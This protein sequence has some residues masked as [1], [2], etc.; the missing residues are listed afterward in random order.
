[1]AFEAIHSMV[2][3]AA[4]RSPGRG[5]VS[6][7]E[8]ELT[9]AAL[10]NAATRVA[11]ELGAAGVGAGRLVP[12]L[13]ED[14]CETITAVLAI[15]K[16][17]AVFVPVDLAAPPARI[18]HILA[19]TRAEHVVVGGLT[20]DGAVARKA[21][22]L[23]R[24]HLPGARLIRVE[25]GKPD[26]HALE[27]DFTP[28]APAPDDPAY[29]MYTS[30]STGRPKGIVGRL[31][32]IDHYIRWETELIGAA[33]GWRVSHLTSPAFDAML[34]DLFVPLTTGGTVCV[35]PTGLLLDPSGLLGWI[36]EQRVQLV[37]CV[38]SIF[39]GLV[40]ASAGGPELLDL[41]CVA[42]SG[43]RLS[44]SDAARWFERH[45]ERIKLLN[46]YGPSETTMTKT[47]HF[48][49]PDDTRRGS[50]PI[51]RPMPGAEVL[52]LDA[53]RRPC[54]AG[55]VG[56]IYLRTPHRSL[57]YRDL[58]EETRA[59]FV[60]NP[61]TGDPADVVYRTGDFGRLLPGGDLEFVGRKDHQVKVGGVRIELGEIESVLRTHPMV[62]DAAAVVHEGT[63]ETPSLCAFLELSGP[64]DNDELRH[65][66]A[67]RLP[68]SAVPSVLVALDELPRTI[69]GKV[70]RRALPAPTVPAP[71]EDQEIVAPRTPTE[72]ALARLWEELLPVEEV[73]VR[74]EFFD[75]GGHSLLVMSMIS[76]LGEEFGVEVHLQAFLAE[77]TIEALAR[78]LEEALVNE[79]GADDDLLDV[80]GATQ[81][82]AGEGTR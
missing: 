70:D 37:H 44:P 3:R 26:Q 71:R 17:G 53:G 16:I 54:E 52:L 67:Q 13:A 21:L 57:G 62:K 8:R 18:G 40:T 80:L 45:G 43:E 9:Y 1:M 2:R 11:T 69:S 22:E 51:G 34:R 64:A 19:D 29:V 47:Y 46:L 75:M 23:C 5:A 27:P 41:R 28:H 65:H 10:E 32:G 61:L 48:V 58:P 6:S 76:R 77:P 25:A 49:T 66:L 82:G 31:G 38:P 12:V 14:R 15:L 81:P 72:K 36:D 24:T 35:P 63:G 55:R 7:P 30:G 74:H 56:E 20:G 68:G 42:M 4:E 39:R 73:G 33:S 59:A 78:Q 60:T 79:P 50:I